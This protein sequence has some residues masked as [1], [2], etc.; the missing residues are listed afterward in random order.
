[1]NM[2]RILGLLFALSSFCAGEELKCSGY[3]C[4]ELLAKIDKLECRLEYTR[5]LLEDKEDKEKTRAYPVS[6]PA[7]VQCPDTWMQYQGSCYLFVDAKRN[8]SGADSHCLGLGAYLVHIESSLEN[9]FLKNHLR[10]LKEYKSYW[11][12]LTD[13]ATEGIHRWIYDNSTTSFTDWHPRQPDNNGGNENCVHMYNYKWND[14]PCNQ[15]LNSI[16]ERKT[17]P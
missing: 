4:D 12:G 9:E 15:S 10:T 1:M 7:C 13:A 11:I 8:F 16:C 3:R 17:N 5:E 14:S 6:T 2:R